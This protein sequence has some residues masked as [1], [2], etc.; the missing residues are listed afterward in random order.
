MHKKTILVTGISR[1][2]GLAL[3]ESLLQSGYNVSGCSR[4]KTEAILHFES[5]YVDSFLWCACAI[6]DES[7]E[8]TFFNATVCHFGENTIY[9]LVN[10]AGIATEGILASFP[11]VELQRM[12]QVNLMGAMRMARLCVVPMMQNSNGRIINISSIIGSNGYTGLTAYSA[13]KAGMD[14]F[15]RSLAR[16]VGRRQI[17]VN[18]VAPGYMKTDMS[19]TLDNTK[20]QQIVRRTPIG[21]LAAVDDVV[22]VIQ[23]LLGDT[24]SAITGQTIAIDGGINC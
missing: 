21:R 19:A 5:T 2:L 12:L 9:G 15:T 22:P 8:Q 18:S 14:G 20:M 17:T 23:F 6:G 4:T 16:E 13:S 3:V 1:G 7:Q 24:A 10:N 11:N